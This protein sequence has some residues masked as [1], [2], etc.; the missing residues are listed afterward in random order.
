MTDRYGRPLLNARFAITLRCN[1][2]CIFCHR[3]GAGPVDSELSYNE[4]GVIAEALSRVGIRKFKVTGGEPLLREDILYV[5]KAIRE[6][7]KGDDISL[8]TNGYYLRERIGGLV[9]AGLSRINVSLHTLNP[10]KFRVIVGVNGLVRVIDS[11]REALSYNLSKIKVNTVVLRGLNDN[12]LWDIV[13]FAEGLGIHVQ[14][15]E[16]HPVGRGKDV[17]SNYFTSINKFLEELNDVAS[18]VLV[19]G[20]LHN[21]PIYQL[22]SGITVEVVRPVMNPL[23][24]AGCSRIRVTPDGSLTPCLNSSVRIPLK[25]IIK[26]GL[27]RDEKIGEIVKVVLSVNNL[28]K[29]SVMWPLDKAVD[30]EYA[31]L[32]RLSNLKR[33]FKLT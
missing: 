11:I 15:I 17:F 1:F 18:K 21:R 26:S 28:R 27:S 20:E 7:G 23:F 31:R 3:E 32:L 8:T 6:F 4:L 24:C 14:F 19:R 33:R 5:I 30:S 29:P 22:P 16:L 12:E 2:N 9:D 10:E 13:R 25:D